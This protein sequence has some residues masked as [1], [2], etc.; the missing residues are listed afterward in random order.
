MPDVSLN[1]Q[2][3]NLSRQ[4]IRQLKAD[5]K[6]TAEELERT[7]DAMVDVKDKSADVKQGLMGISIG[8]GIASAALGA[9]VKGWI[10]ASVQM[11]KMFKGLTA[12]AGGAAEAKKQFVGL[13]EVAKLPGLGLP[14]AV[15]GS[16][17]L[18]AVGFSAKQAEEALMAF[19]NALATVGKGRAELDGVIL[20]L[21][22]MRAKGKVMGDDLRQIANYLPQIRKAMLDAF[23]TASSKNLQEMNVSAERFI[24]T[25]VREFQK[26][27]GVMG[28]AANAV[29][30]L[31]DSMFQLKSN[32]GN[33]LLPTYIAILD[34]VSA[35]VAAMDEW[36]ETRK[37]IMVWSTVSV[38]GITSVIGAVTGL[39]F[40]K[41]QLIGALKLLGTTVTWLF[42]TPWGLAITGVAALAAGIA[43]LIARSK[44]ARMTADKFTRTLDSL[45]KSAEKLKTIEEL[46]E[47]V[48][49]L[50]E[51]VFKTAKE[52]QELI[53]AQN[54]LAELAPRLVKAYDA[55]GNA[56]VDVGEAMKEFLEDLREADRIISRASYRKAI[57]ERDRLTEAM[58]ENRE[59]L[60]RLGRGLHLEEKRLKS[61]A[62]FMRAETE[63]RR[64]Y[65]RNQREEVARTLQ[66]NATELQKQVRAIQQYERE[67]L[68]YGAKL[69]PTVP[70]V[71]AA[72]KP[73]A[74][75]EEQLKEQTELEIREAKARAA[76]IEDEY[77]SR[78]ALAKAEAIE[79]RKELESRSKNLEE[80][81][82]KGIKTDEEAE[83]ERSLIR[84]QRAA[85]EAEVAQKI[86]DINEDEAKAKEKLAKKSGTTVEDIIEDRVRAEEEAAEKIQTLHAETYRLQEQNYR[87]IISLIDD[88]FNQQEAQADFAYLSEGRRLED[89]EKQLRK[90]LETASIGAKERE[91]AEEQLTQVMAAQYANR[92]VWEKAKKRITEDRTKHEI[93]EQEKLDKKISDSRMR[94]MRLLIS[95]LD[96]EQAKRRGMII[97]DY[98]EEIEKRQA[99]IDN[100]KSSTEERAQAEKELAALQ[101]ALI[102]ELDAANEEFEKDRADARKKRDKEEEQIAKKRIGEAEQVAA[103]WREN[104]WI[105][106]SMMKEGLDKEIAILQQRYAD[107][108][109]QI[110]AIL[111]DEKTSIEERTA[112]EQRLSLLRMEYAQN[113]RKA[114]LGHYD[115]IQTLA[116]QIAALPT[117]MIHM[118]KQLRDVQ[119]EYAQQL[120]GVYAEEKQMIAEVRWD[121]E[122]TAAERARNIQQ[123]E[124]ASAERRY[125]IEQELIERQEA[126]WKDYV[127][128]FLGG[129]FK[130][131]E[132]DI[133]EELS[134]RIVKFLG[135][136]FFKQKGAPI[137]AFGGIDIGKPVAPQMEGGVDWGSVLM[138]GVKALPWLLAL[139]RAEN[140]LLARS[141]GHVAA[142]KAAS[143]DNPL[144]DWRAQL[145]GTMTASRGL[146]ERSAKDLIA[147]FKAGFLQTAKVHSESGESGGLTDVLNAIRDRLDEP[148][149]FI[150]QIGGRE[151]ESVITRIRDKRDFRGNAY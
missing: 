86:K 8:A 116:D 52:T 26:L 31:S 78:R 143:F 19:G 124:R 38:A 108:T 85:L 20:A 76:A 2:G 67:Y 122:M 125:Q 127:Y 145:A 112:L 79:E 109:S 120:R 74:P 91:A 28:G 14:E 148:P 99:I 146:G 102:A 113:Y 10:S 70:P 151:L 55:Q 65:F 71:P 56:I 16:I 100:V 25:I 118:Y 64:N 42:T 139:D 60:T 34:K 90:I 149:K 98:K 72:P 89:Q 50:G 62:R 134:G 59:E 107:E 69:K 73:Y 12:V 44:A 40:V 36:S 48:R 87:A 58:K 88:R 121:A 3:R 93:E 15:K 37:K 22:Q 43:I 33:V 1:I 61:G 103:A 147:N 77:E 81:V 66:Q 95:A 92:L 114:L 68:G 105:R 126:L 138:T 39:M 141:Y 45:N 4:A 80:A 131:I 57:E 123:I 6:A 129:L 132:E 111:K 94:T 140:D 18:Q 47:K 11:E 21:T 133:Q 23:G 41:E 32:L 46:G 110:A 137:P 24:E 97:A 63:Q 13:R 17:S 83:Y 96:N 7:E 51:K 142:L 119:N 53:D 144:N 130:E 29:E 82:K 75:T 27:P 117:D 5:L 35:L 54:K 135:D 128:S 106:I 30:N 9:L 104:E 49:K 136:I 101:L 84:R 150:L 115:I